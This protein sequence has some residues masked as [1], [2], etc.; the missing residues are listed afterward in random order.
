M[1]LSTLASAFLAAWFMLAPPSGVQAYQRSGGL[2]E[3]RQPNSGRFQLEGNVAFGPQRASVRGDG[4]FVQPDRIQLTMEAQADGQRERLELV[5]L[6]ETAYTRTGRSPRWDIQNMPGAGAIRP[7]LDGRS[8]VPTDPGLAEA[9]AALQMVGIEPLRG[10]PTERYHGDFD[11]LALA[12]ELG[13]PDPA[14]RDSIRSLTMGLDF[15][16]GVRDRYLHQMK[17]AIEARAAR[18]RP[19]EPD[20]ATADL[21][22]SL[23]NFDQPITITAPVGSPS[24]ALTPCPAPAPAQVP[25][26]L[27]RAPAR[28]LGR[29]RSLVGQDD[30][31]IHRREDAAHDQRH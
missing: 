29:R 20:S 6:G 25:V 5:V 1:D 18:P 2:P 30:L 16:I 22:F 3:L 10:I 24:A 8:G 9:L 12:E 23:S 19:G 21:L 7:P 4:C 13:P 31:D 11:L 26:Q 14:L 15:W 27:P 17:L 28:L